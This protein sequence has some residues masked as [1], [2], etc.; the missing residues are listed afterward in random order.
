MKVLV[1]IE[2]KENAP[3]GGSL[4]LLTAAAALGEAAA[5]VVEDSAAAQAAAGFGTPV[6]VLKTDDTCPDAQVAAI[7]NRQPH[8]LAICQGI[9]N[10]SR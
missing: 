7:D 6:T 4:E 8:S 5:V 2:A 3:M 9:A 1:Y 10:Q